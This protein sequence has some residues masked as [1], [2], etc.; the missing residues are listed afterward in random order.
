[1]YCFF[2]SKTMG[3][4]F[5][6]RKENCWQNLV[7]LSVLKIYILSLFFHLLFC[8]GKKQQKNTTKKHRIMVCFPS[9]VIILE[10]FFQQVKTQEQTKKYFTSAYFARERR[11]RFF[12]PLSLTLANS[13]RLIALDNFQP[14]TFGRSNYWSY[15]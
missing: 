1:M 11:L 13:P 6:P 8:V 7:P 3:T 14:I 15:Q 2:W 5:H 10:S 12:V 9:K 4:L